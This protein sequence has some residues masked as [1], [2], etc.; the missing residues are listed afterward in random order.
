MQRLE[1]VE[2]L[3][4]DMMHN[5]YKCPECGKLEY[6]GMLVMRNGHH[7]CRDCIYDIW[8]KE[9]CQAAKLKEYEE[10]DREGRK[11]L[12][13]RISFW[14]RSEKDLIFPY[15]EGGENLYEKLKK[16]KE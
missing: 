13:E 14:R 10:A 2:K 16:E 12:I 15:Y 3:D 1:L 9:G 11:P 7:Y 5:I 8:E 6:Y 4:D